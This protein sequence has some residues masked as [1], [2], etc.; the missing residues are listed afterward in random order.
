MWRRFE[1]VGTVALSAVLL[2][3]GCGTTGKRDKDLAIAPPPPS[4]VEPRPEKDLPPDRAVKVCLSVAEELERSGYL[5]EAAEQY[6]KALKYDPRSLQATH[7]LA[8][9]YDSQGDVVRAQSGYKHAL[10]LSPK[11]PALLNDMGYFCYE[12]G[13]WSEAEDWLRKALAADPKNARARI[14]LGMAL[15][16]QGKSQ[17]ALAAFNKVVGPAEA[18]ANLGMILAQCGQ[19]EEAKKAL[20]QSLT[21]E[22]ASKVV[23]A[24]LARLEKPAPTEALRD[25][26]TIRTSISK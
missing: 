20:Q 1:W 9:I 17:E 10:E 18:Q 22:P 3:A 4:R 13:R 14:N 5:T 11:D 15:A 21:L 8:V 24:A 7:R 2:A 6:N 26:E 12:R 16:Q 23:Q 25:P 19:L